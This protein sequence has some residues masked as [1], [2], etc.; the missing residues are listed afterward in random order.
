MQNMYNERFFLLLPT[1]IQLCLRGSP[2]VSSV[3]SESIIFCWVLLQLTKATQDRMLFLLRICISDS[4][5][6][7]SPVELCRCRDLKCGSGNKKESTISDAAILHLNGNDGSHPVPFTSCYIK[8]DNVGVVL[9][10]SYYTGHVSDSRNRG[11]IVDVV[12]Q[13]RIENFP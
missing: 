6:Y 10:I 5:D 3:D 9:I 12:T 4:Q 7:L 2:G 1:E 13:G 11:R 8:G